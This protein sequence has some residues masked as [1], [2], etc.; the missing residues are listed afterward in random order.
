MGSVHKSLGALAGR[1]LTRESQTGE[2]QMESKKRQIPIPYDRGFL[3]KYWDFLGRGDKLLAKR[4]RDA[5]VPQYGHYIHYIR[6]E[7]SGS[8]YGQPFKNFTVQSFSVLLGNA[9]DININNYGGILHASGNEVDGIRRFWQVWLMDVQFKGMRSFIRY[10][11]NQPSNGGLVTIENINS[12]LQKALNKNGIGQSTGIVVGQ[13]A[14]LLPGLKIIQMEESKGGRSLDSGK[15]D[16]LTHEDLVGIYAY[17]WA[18]HQNKN[19]PPPNLGDLEAYLDVERTT[20]YRWRKKNNLTSTE[21]LNALKQE[22]I[23]ASQS[24]SE[25]KLIQLTSK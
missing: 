2:G 15:L 18:Y 20:F 19:L 23:K 3:Q 24:I 9:E 1:N 21:Q 5:G 8:S 14:H 4:L 12:D 16:N 11:W 17:L 22:A 6:I 25:D 13:L 10:I 7:T